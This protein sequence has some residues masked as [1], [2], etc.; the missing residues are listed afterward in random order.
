MNS[1]AEPVLGNLDD[2]G[3]HIPDRRPSEKRGPNN[4]PRKPWLALVLGIVHS[5][6]AFAYVGRG[7][8]GIALV[9]LEI[10]LAAAAGWTGVLQSI[11]VYW[12]L[13]SVLVVI[14]TIGIF[15]PWIIARGQT[16][17]YELRWY[18]RWY[19]YLAIAVALA[20][21]LQYAFANKE[22]LFGFGTY[23]VPSASMAPTIGAGDYVL[24]DTR[25]QTVASLRAGD[26]VVTASAS[27]P[28]QL[29]VKRIVGMP[30]QHVVVGEGGLTIDGVVQDR[31]HMQGSDMLPPEA[32]KFIDVTLG[33]NEFYLMGDNRANSRDS[34]SEGPYRRSDLR[35]KAT[36][37]WYS[38]EWWRLGVVH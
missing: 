9:A 16:R 37:I 10:A 36:T 30:G 38:S 5:P 31:S 35:G 24:A 29:F 22:S 7:F 2:I 11:V 19:W 17:S 23:R 12:G 18:N 3:T 4:R 13:L 21:P 8:L 26:I 28:R 14:M 33:A 27:Q 25:P 32:M 34:R 6:I 20:L 1:R 15:A